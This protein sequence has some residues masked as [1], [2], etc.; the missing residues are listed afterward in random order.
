MS[1]RWGIGS[2]RSV[3]DV[4]QSRREGLCTPVAGHPGTPV[5]EGRFGVG[6]AQDAH[7]HQEKRAAQPVPCSQGRAVPDGPCRPN[8]P[9][10]SH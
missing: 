8:S 5:R 1:H 3:D 6:E 9:R 7:K 10:S 2:G 4:V